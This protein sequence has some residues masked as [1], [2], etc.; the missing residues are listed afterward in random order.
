MEQDKFTNEQVVIYPQDRRIEIN[1]TVPERAYGLFDTKTG[2]QVSDFVKGNGGKI[3]F[4]H[5]DSS[6]HFDVGAVENMSDEK[7]YFAI[8]WNAQMRDNTDEILNG[9]DNMPVQYPHIY[10]IIDKGNNGVLEMVD[11]NNEPVGQVMELSSTGDKPYFKQMWSMRI[12][13]DA[14]ERLYC[15]II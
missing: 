14:T 10:K 9:F 7:P 5:L 1:Y 6:I 4:N 11:D 2:T 8:N 13:N 15:R 3:E 12:K